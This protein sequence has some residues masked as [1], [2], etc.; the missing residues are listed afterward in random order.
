MAAILLLALVVVKGSHGQERL[1]QIGRNEA[2]M[3]VA[4]AVRGGEDEV[5]I[6]KSQV[7]FYI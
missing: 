5:Q 6:K 7:L 4:E 3:P 1:E 2:K